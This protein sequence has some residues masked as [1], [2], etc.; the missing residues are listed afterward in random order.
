MTKLY[1]IALAVLCA[2]SAASVSAANPPKVVF[3]GDYLT[4]NWTYPAN[5][6][7]FNL[8]V[9][10][11]DILTNDGNSGEWA[12]NFQTVLN[13]HPDIVHIMV[14][15]E[16]AALEDDG[17]I[18]VVGSVF[19]QNIQQMV[20]MAKSSN[21]KI[22][23]GTTPPSTPGSIG[24]TEMNGFI[25][26]YG[27]ANGITVVNYA[28]A[29]C[30]CIGSTGAVGVGNSYPPPA[31]GQTYHPSPLMTTTTSLVP[32]GYPAIPVPTADGY[33]L[34][35]QMVENAIATTMGA[36]LKSGYL[37]NV[38]FGMG[39]GVNS[40]VPYFNQNSVVPGMSLQFTP[41]GTYSDNVTRPLLNSNFAG[42]S[43]T[44]TSNNPSVMYV[45]PNGLAYALSPG[46]AWIS[47]VSP[48][49]VAFS[50]WVMTVS[51]GIPAY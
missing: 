31:P 38:D 14:G 51:S 25:Q 39:I 8:G 24:I 30:G 28:D 12:Q 15:A 49:G 47:Y 6:N 5:P 7:W 29:L 33:A 42:S 18:P 48:Q 21:I 35:T 11:P 13:L 4:A 3:I 43:G 23:L 16:D 26:Q 41:W 22:I 2:F 27:A 44:W 37:Q 32:G 1:R 9:D 36:T 19:A 46:T 34:M 10:T 20:Q 17:T 45:T 50:P 40:N